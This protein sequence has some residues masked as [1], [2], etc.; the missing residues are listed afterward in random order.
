MK[1][2][3]AT[4]LS[5]VGVLAT[6]GVALA[7]N[8]AVLD[9]TV[10]SIDGPLPL[11]EAIVPG[12][13]VS[14]DAT[15]PVESTVPPET[16]RTASETIASAAAV[17]SAYDVRGVGIV[18]LKR[19]V[20]GLDV[21]AV[22]PVLGW[23][24]DAESERLNRVEIKFSNGTQRV[25]FNAELLDGRIISSV[26]AIDTSVAPAAKGDGSDEGEDDGEG[27]DD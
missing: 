21:V 5:I 3:I 6:G 12:S 16:E 4:T 9:S 2:S 1:T 27:D 10:S 19:S 25:K 26:Q 8:T 17:E 15:M 24:Y 20:T 11:V 14:A 18:T 22:K 13:V 7:V 23:S